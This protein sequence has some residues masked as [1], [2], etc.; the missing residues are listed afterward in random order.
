MGKGDLKVKFEITQGSKRVKIRIY[1]VGFRLIKE[2]IKEGEYM[3]G[4]NTIRIESKYFNKIA[5]GT[6]YLIITA[7]NEESKSVNSKPVILIILNNYL[8]G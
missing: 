8:R 7:I 3:A 4:V 2:I 5:N 1:T 6:Y